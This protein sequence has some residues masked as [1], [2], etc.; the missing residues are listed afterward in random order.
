MTVEREDG[1]L[2][3]H[4]VGRFPGQAEAMRA[5]LD[6]FVGSWTALD[7]GRWGHV[8]AAR[9]EGIDLWA[10]SVGADSAHVFTTENV[11]TGFFA[12]LASLGEERLRGRR[13]LIAADC[14]PSLHFMLSGAAERLGFELVTVPIEPG[15]VWVEDDDVVA[16]WDERVALAVLTWVSS[17]SSHRTDLDRLVSHGRAMGSLVAADATQGVGV[18]PFDVGAPAI[19]FAATTVLKWCCGVPGAGFAYMAPHLVAEARPLLTGW[20]SQPDPFNWDLDRFALADGA[21]RFDNGTPSYLPFIA[22]L[23]GLRWSAACDRAAMLAHNQ[24]SIDAMRDVA[25]AYGLAAVSPGADVPRGPTLVVGTGGA[26]EGTDLVA[27]LARHDLHADSRGARVRLSPGPAFA[28]ET[29]ER[30]GEA[31]QA[32]TRAQAA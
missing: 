19:D 27:R 4:S 28:P 12:F 18:L 10:A 17:T 3:F 2:L 24:A 23:P 11:T 1:W 7:G 29:L 13:V 15:A 9:R 25:E 5:E 21:R 8:D 31:L 26:E 16:A 30:L 6:G 14:F 32:H 22:S 20:F